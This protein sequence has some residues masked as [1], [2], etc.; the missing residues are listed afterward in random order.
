LSD[1]PFI[2]WLHHAASLHRLTGQIAN[3]G[4]CEFEEFC[5]RK[6]TPPFNVD[7]PGVAQLQQKRL[8]LPSESFL[9]SA[10]AAAT[11]LHDGRSLVEDS[12][13]G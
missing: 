6:P 8:F 11:N 9:R 12:W 2:A 1:K 5:A 4:T 13:C 3:T 7:R 10:A